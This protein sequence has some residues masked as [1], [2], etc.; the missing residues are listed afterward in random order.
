MIFVSK[1]FDKK[2]CLY[3]TFKSSQVLKFSLY[4][5]TVLLSCL[6]E[7]KGF[8]YFYLFLTFFFYH[9]DSGLKDEAYW[10]K[11]GV[12]LTL[13]W[14]RN[15]DHNLLTLYIMGFFLSINKTFLTEACILCLYC[16]SVFVFDL[17][18]DVTMMSFLWPPPA[19]YLN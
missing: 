12:S 15:T 14:A 11:E 4:N 6:D 7:S 19:N 8:D 13:L 16:W 10:N 3:R 1:V 17:S 9:I 2:I 18:R 5:I